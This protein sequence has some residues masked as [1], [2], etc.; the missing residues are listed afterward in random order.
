[1]QYPSSQREGGSATVG[2]K[3]PSPSP[4]L[5][6]LTLDIC[7]TF[8]SRL[9]CSPFTLYLI[10]LQSLLSFAQFAWHT[11][12]LIFVAQFFASFLHSL[13]FT[14]NL[15]FV[16]PFLHSLLNFAELYVTLNLI[17][18]ALFWHSF[19]QFVCHIKLALCCPFF[20]QFAQFCIV[21][22]SH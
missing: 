19:A 8:F 6:T 4:S 1:M 11:I 17:F 15:I 2:G 14:L 10:F 16:A 7:C 22:M 3:G 20:A 18:V 12:H 5:V 13:H 21:C 9:H